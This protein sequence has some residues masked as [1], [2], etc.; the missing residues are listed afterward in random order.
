MKTVGDLFL[1][2]VSTAIQQQNSHV[3][4]SSLSCTLTGIRGGVVCWTASVFRLGL[5]VELKITFR[6]S[7]MVQLRLKT[8]IKI[9]RCMQIP[10]CVK[11]VKIGIEN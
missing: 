3:N 11:Q 2:S 6:V 8:K 5:L 10:I 9:I 7:G 1:E 4:P